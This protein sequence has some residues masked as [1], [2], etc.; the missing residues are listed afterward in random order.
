MATAS[1]ETRLTRETLLQPDD[2][3][4]NQ[5]TLRPVMYNRE[6][7][8]VICVTMYNVSRMATRRC[9]RDLTEIFHLQEDE[10]LLTRTLHGVMSESS[11]LNTQA[12]T[13]KNSFCRK[14]CPS[15]F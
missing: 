3:E 8:L 13:D 5:Y 1:L 4:K 15:M 9:R 2:F 10:I 14:Y 11:F 12:D 7:E 6:T